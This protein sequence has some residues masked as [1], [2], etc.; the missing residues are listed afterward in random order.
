MHKSANKYV[1]LFMFCRMDNVCLLMNKTEFGRLTPCAYGL[2]VD[3][4]EANDV[5][6]INHSSSSAILCV[7]CTLELAEGEKEY[8]CTNSYI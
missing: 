3:C 1:C 2:V 8:K 5:G 7:R 6:D 4:K